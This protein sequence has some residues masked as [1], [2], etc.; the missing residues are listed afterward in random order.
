MEH[1]EQLQA[2]TRKLNALAGKTKE[3]LG[4][5]Q[6]LKVTHAQRC[7]PECF[8]MVHAY[9]A[10]NFIARMACGSLHRHR[11]RP[12]WRARRLPRRRL[13]LRPLTL[14]ITIITAST[15]TQHT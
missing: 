10:I 8:A 4:V 13:V 14:F 6:K 2:A 3:L 9:D 12:F 7:T 1:E 11:W 15:H 5:N